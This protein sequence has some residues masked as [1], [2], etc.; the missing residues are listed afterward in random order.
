MRERGTNQGDE[1]KENK[2]K[3]VGLRG[4]CDQVETPFYD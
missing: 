2:T 4:I 1:Y 3:L